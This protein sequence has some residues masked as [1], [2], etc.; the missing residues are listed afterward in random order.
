MRPLA[1]RFQLTV[2][3]EYTPA[4]MASTLTT[5]GV[6]HTW[7]EDPGFGHDYQIWRLYL[8]RLL[9]QTFRD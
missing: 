4:A 5:A 1:D 2:P 8:H 7:S 3:V 6:K 9:Q